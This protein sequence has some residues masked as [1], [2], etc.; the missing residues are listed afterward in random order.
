[1]MERVVTTKPINGI[2]A[3]QV[4]VVADAS[5][6]EILAH[7]NR[8]NPS[9]TSLGWVAVVRVKSPDGPDGPVACADDPGRLHI[10]VRC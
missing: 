4:C 7:A 9:G 10:L 6:D 5:D 1:M 8:D 3:M 2:C